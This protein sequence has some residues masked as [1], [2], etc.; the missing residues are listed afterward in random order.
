[1]QLPI[2]QSAFTNAAA[3]ESVSSSAAAVFKCSCLATHVGRTIKSRL[4]LFFFFFYVLCNDLMLSPHTKLKSANLNWP[5]L[6]V[7]STNL[8]PTKFSGHII[9]TWPRSIQFLAIQKLHK[10]T[11]HF[12]QLPGLQVVLPSPVVCPTPLSLLHRFHQATGRQWHR[13]HVCSSLLA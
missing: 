13:S 5:H 4:Q 3:C 6:C 12:H 11:S 2:G 9:L 8:I 10:S 7:Y 1:M